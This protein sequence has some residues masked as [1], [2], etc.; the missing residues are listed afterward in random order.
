MWSEMRDSIRCPQHMYYVYVYLC[1]YYVCMYV[2][3]YVSCM[4][5]VCMYNVCADWRKLLLWLGDRSASGSVRGLRPGPSAGHVIGR[6]WPAGV[7]AWS[8]G[9]AGES[10]QSVGRESAAGSPSRRLDSR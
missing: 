5:N 6:V 10:A 3:L 9:R 4:Y 8:Q 1:M 2:C 7:A